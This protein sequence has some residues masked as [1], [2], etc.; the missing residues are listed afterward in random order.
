MKDGEN[1]YRH[2]NGNPIKFKDP[3]GTKT[4][5]EPVNRTEVVNVFKA[6]VTTD[7]GKQR[8]QNLSDAEVAAAYEAVIYAE[9]DRLNYEDEKKEN[10]D[11]I[12]EAKRELKADRRERTRAFFR[13]DFKA[14]RE[15]KDEVGKGRKELAS[16]REEKRIL[17][18]QKNLRGH[19]V[20]W[21]T[22][23]LRYEDG[24][25]GI[26]AAIPG[27]NRQKISEDETRQPGA[28]I[29]LPDLHRAGLPTSKVSDIHSHTKFGDPAQAEGSDAS[30]SSPSGLI[31]SDSDRETAA[32]SKVRHIMINQRGRVV[33]ISPQGGADIELK[34]GLKEKSIING[35]LGAVTAIKKDKD[36]GTYK[37]NRRVEQARKVLESIQRQNLIKFQRSI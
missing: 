37:F 3:E 36:I 27:G 19:D 32:S 18:N 33:M 6:G 28:D 7:I 22:S 17:E 20:E 2:V 34:P 30:I 11:L 26:T 9:A 10:I 13:G 35:E 15:K 8:Y 24:T 14:Y 21:V 29:E 12:G 5:E 23:V 4:I 16:L 31:P 25:Y 1:L